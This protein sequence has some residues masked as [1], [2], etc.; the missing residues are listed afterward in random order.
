MNKLKKGAAYYR[1]MGGSRRADRRDS[2]KN[3]SAPKR[4]SATAVVCVSKAMVGA[5]EHPTAGILKRF[6]LGEPSAGEARIVVR[7]LLA[8]CAE[9]QQ[10]VR[11]ISARISV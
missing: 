2:S 11:R 3:L 9:C 1:A 5:K 10:E 6:A 7:H 8:G 4:R